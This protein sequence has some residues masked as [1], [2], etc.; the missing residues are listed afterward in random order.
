MLLRLDVYRKINK[1]ICMKKRTLHSQGCSFDR[2]HSVW[3]I[4]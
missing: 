1:S 4:E 2:S 3:D